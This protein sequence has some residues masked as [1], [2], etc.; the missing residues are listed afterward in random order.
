MATNLVTKLWQND[1]LPAL[2][3]M[4]FQN[5]MGYHYLNMQT[6]S[7][8]DAAIS[9]KNFMNFGP[10]TPE[11]MGLIYKLFVRHGKK[12]GVFSRISQHL[13]DW[14]VRSFQ[15][16][17]APLMQMINLYI[18]FRF[19]EGRFNGSQLIFGKMPWTL[20][21]TTCILCTIVRK[22]VAMSR[23]NLL[24]TAEMMWLYRVKI[25]WTSVR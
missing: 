5:G 23:L 8:N 21:D 16:M 18:V 7:I 13:L 11:K 1:L 6:K 15:R 17:K 20:T 19:V 14:F 22:W 12:S 10:V 9:C 25:W 2:S 3:A 24:L 4:W